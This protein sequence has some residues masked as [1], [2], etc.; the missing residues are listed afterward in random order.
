MTA[1]RS[2]LAGFVLLSSLV[3]MAVMVPVSIVYT[4]SYPL[5]SDPGVYGEAAEFFVVEP[6]N[7]AFRRPL[8]ENL[9]GE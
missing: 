6:A 3:G 7:F 2:L 4:L 8:G 9:S 5:H 1:K